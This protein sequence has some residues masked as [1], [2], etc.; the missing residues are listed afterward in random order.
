MPF[1]RLCVAFY[2]AGFSVAAFSAESGIASTQT[3]DPTSYLVKTLISIVVVVALAFAVILL[4]KRFNQGFLPKNN[5]IKIISTVGLGAKEKLVLVGLRETQLLIGVTPGAI[6]TLF[7]LPDG[8]NAG[9]SDS[10]SRA[11]FSG[12]MDQVVRKESND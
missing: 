9:E 7:V 2:I 1:K 10:S 12:I 3:F 5:Q 11:D 8:E 6:N 4:M